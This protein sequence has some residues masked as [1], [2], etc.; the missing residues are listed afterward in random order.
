MYYHVPNMELIMQDKD[1]SCWY[2]SAQMLVKQKRKKE[3]TQNLLDP[4][5]ITNWQKLYT[6][7]I[8]ITNA[9]IVSFAKATGLKMIPPM[10]PTPE[11]IYWWL[12]IYGPLWVNGRKHITVIAGIKKAGN[13]FY[14]LVY[15]PAKDRPFGE[16]RNL[17]R[18]YIND[19]WSGRDTSRAVRTIFL[20]APN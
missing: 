1:M 10:S 15:D 2:A 5:Q 3:S 19:T 9:K 11:A 7:D 8:G 12:R 6:D 4:S 18:W 17:T 13:K 20:Y 14:L 16:W